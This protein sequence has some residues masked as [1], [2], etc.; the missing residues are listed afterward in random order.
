MAEPSRDYA[1]V[2]PMFRRLTT[3]NRDS[4][5]FRSQRDE[6]IR[7]CLP[8][9]DHIARRFRNRGEPLEDL[10]Q[11]ARLGL[12]NAVNR[13]DIETGSEFLSFAVPTIM[14]EVRRHFRDHGWSVKVPRAVKELSMHIKT[15]SAELSQTLGRA[16]TATE[17]ADHLGV[18][19]EKVVEGLIAWSS[20]STSST[21]AP[22]PADDDGK[23][24]RE[25]MG[26]L[27]ANF[28]KVLDIQTVRPLIAALP[29]R[30][31]TVLLLRFFH[32][33]SQSEI[34]KRID[35]SQMQ[36]SRILSRAIA[37]VR[38]Q[39]QPQEATASKMDRHAFVA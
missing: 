20:Y 17:L 1:E 9:A 39:A 21:D 24:P 28:D 33:L 14:G 16:P 13:Y 11:V 3:L 32:N 4:S 19:R 6:I 37:T 29:E 38:D 5:A 23:A 8:L 12:V 34:A 22:A 7:C 10:V 30:E 27:D 15:G 31:R 25:I 36:V 35:V 26:S 2:N 18:N